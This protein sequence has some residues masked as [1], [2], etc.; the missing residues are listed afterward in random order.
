MADALLIAFVF[1][2][3]E[4]ESGGEHPQFLNFCLTVLNKQMGWQEEER[5]VFLEAIV[6]QLAA[7]LLCLREKSCLGD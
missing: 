1:C 5:T 2:K 3:E 4:V 6:T 7:A